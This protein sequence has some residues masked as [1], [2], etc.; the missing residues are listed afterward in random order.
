M[1]NGYS[2]GQVVSFHILGCGGVYIGRGTNLFQALG[3]TLPSVAIAPIRA[4]NMNR[5]RATCHPPLLPDAALRQL[6]VLNRVPALA[7]HLATSSNCFGSTP[8][9]SPANSNV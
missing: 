1:D 8:D 3:N 6:C 7:T 5:L 2:R 9:S 4:F